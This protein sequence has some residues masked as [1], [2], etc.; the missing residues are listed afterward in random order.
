ML[1]KLC[2]GVLILLVVLPFTAP[3]PTC[4]LSAL[5]AHRGRHHS[6][7]LCPFSAPAAAVEAAGALVPARLTKSGR[8]RIHLPPEIASVAVAVTTPS[9][10]PQPSLVSKSRQ[11][12]L[13]K[14]RL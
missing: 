11:S 9:A 6:A 14:L 7:M 2:A 13:L 8:L 4:D 12:L 3:F 1:R 10:I 5:N